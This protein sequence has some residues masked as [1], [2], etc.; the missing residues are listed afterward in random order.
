MGWDVLACLC[1]CWHWL[2]LDFYFFFIY[3]CSGTF[4]WIPLPGSKPNSRACSCERLGTGVPA[5]CLDDTKVGD[6]MA[7]EGVFRKIKS[8]I[9]SVKLFVMG[10]VSGITNFFLQN[11][12][13][14]GFWGNIRFVRGNGRKTIFEWPKVVSEVSFTRFWGVLCIAKCFRFFVSVIGSAVSEI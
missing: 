13:I 3:L 9:S 10:K 14:G 1:L 8:S 5:G 12:D 2:V 7:R 4:S 11:Q 6:H